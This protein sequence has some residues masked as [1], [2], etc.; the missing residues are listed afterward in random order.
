MSRNTAAESGGGIY[1]P[2]TAELTNSTVS[3]NHAAK[4]ATPIRRD[5]PPS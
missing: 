4:C 1:T 3:G 2:R 5:N